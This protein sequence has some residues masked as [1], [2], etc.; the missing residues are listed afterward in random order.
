MICPDCQNGMVPH[1]LAQIRTSMEFARLVPCPR[2]KGS[3]MASFLDDDLA[4]LLATLALPVE[5][6]DLEVDQ[7]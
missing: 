2:C 3:G 1:P 4:S 5:L 6:Q 7:P